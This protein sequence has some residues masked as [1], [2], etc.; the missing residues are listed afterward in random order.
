[1][2]PVDVAYASHEKYIQTILSAPIS[3]V[4]REV[5]KYFNGIYR[6][7]NK[8]VFHKP[9]TFVGVVDGQERDEADEA[10]GDSA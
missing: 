5:E 7:L 9:V 1:L 3:R 8:I 2:N 4:E 6:D 10:V